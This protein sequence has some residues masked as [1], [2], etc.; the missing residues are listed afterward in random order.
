[1]NP[2]SILKIQHLFIFFKLYFE[3]LINM[4]D[5]ICPYLNKSKPSGLVTNWNALFLIIWFY[6]T[7]SLAGNTPMELWFFYL[8][9]FIQSFNKFRCFGSRRNRVPLQSYRRS[10]SKCL[11]YANYLSVR[12][13]DGA[14]KGTEKEKEKILKYQRRNWWRI[15][16][17]ELCFYIELRFSLNES[18]VQPEIK[19]GVQVATGHSPTILHAKRSPRKIKK[20]NKKK[21]EN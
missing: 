5:S 15:K 9:R 12:A 13:L 16:S 11:A 10:T 4:F 20:K 2:L 19:S 14:W 6:S 17:S 3:S 8:F 1:M 7:N 18:G 21:K